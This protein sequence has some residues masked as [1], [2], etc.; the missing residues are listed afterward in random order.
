MVSRRNLFITFYFARN[1][2]L[3]SRRLKFLYALKMNKIVYYAEVLRL[4]LDW[5]QP[6]FLQIN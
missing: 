1:L 4:L 5:Q 2:F 6:V 3:I